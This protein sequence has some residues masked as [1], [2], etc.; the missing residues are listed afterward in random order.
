MHLPRRRLPACLAGLAALLP[1]ARATLA[2]PGLLG[3]QARDG[4]VLSAGL[5]LYLVQA[6]AGPPILF[7][8][9]L[10]DDWRLY[11]YQ[12]KEFS[13][14]HQVAAANLR[15]FAPSD[16][17]GDPAD[18]AMPRLLEDVHALLD[19]F[20]GPPA[21]LVG[22][23]WGGYG[24]WVFASAWPERVARLVILNA[25]HPAIHLR[26]IRHD[27]A[28]ILA[29]QYERDFH[30]APAP[31]PAWYNYYRADPIKV[32]ASAAEAAGMPMPDLAAHFFAGLARAPGRTD[33][34]ITVPTLVIWGMQDP[35]GLPG[36]L[37][38]LGDYVPVLRVLRIEAA[39]H[40]PMRTHPE[41]VNRAMREFL[42]Q[43]R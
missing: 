22:N 29:S 8:H 20:G 26:E 1:S 36:Q 25:P 40:Y 16:V 15:G 6:G 27:P 41:A 24:A 9:G 31:Y 3:P 35:S 39:G 19:H 42:R 2:Q 14:D 32:P 37:D 11:E 38:G 7:L 12:L 10:P 23:D 17:P 30:A 5:R 13:R 18:Y 43:R 33:L 34:R 28:Q 4:Y 21:V